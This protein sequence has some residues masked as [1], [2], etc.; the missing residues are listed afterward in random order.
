MAKELLVRYLS[1]EEGCD[2]HR[3]QVKGHDALAVKECL[4][5]ERTLDSLVEARW[6]VEDVISW[7]WHPI[8]FPIVQC[9]KFTVI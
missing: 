4:G 6:P 2:D 3:A 8:L 9:Q 7:I 1:D 5:K